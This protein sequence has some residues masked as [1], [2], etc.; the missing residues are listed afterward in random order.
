M[1]D[2][3]EDKLGV[4]GAELSVE[5]GAAQIQI[6]QDVNKYVMMASNLCCM[7]LQ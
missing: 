1:V 3:D 4:L 5:I 2:G 6:D 7:I